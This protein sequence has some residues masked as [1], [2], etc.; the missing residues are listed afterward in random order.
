MSL[1]C[2]VAAPFGDAPFVREVHARLRALGIEPTSAWAE[3]ADGPEL[4]EEMP[5]DDVR[6]LAA[7]NDHALSVS[8]VVLVLPREG[9]GREMFAESRLA[10]AFGIPV[11]WVGFPRCLTSYREG[12]DRFPSLEAALA[13]LSQRARAHAV[14]SFEA[15]VPP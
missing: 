8:D 13:H 6:A 1:R 15:E 4:L 14:V 10:V 11:L 9:A 7:R 5:L 12:V 3:H 2:Y